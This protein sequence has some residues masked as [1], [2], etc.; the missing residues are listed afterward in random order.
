VFTPDD[1][2]RS[3]TDLNT[4]TSLK[5]PVWLSPQESPQ[6]IHNAVSKLINFMSQPQDDSEVEITEVQVNK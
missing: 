6:A 3:Q 4:S 1:L 2:S 5:R